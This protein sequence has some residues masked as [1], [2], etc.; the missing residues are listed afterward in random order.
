MKPKALLGLV[1]RLG[2]A[3]V[4]VW[5]LA[6]QLQ[7]DDSLV[8]VD[9]TELTGSVV[10][11]DG[12]AFE[13]KL[14]GEAPVV[15]VPADEVRERAAGVPDVTYGLRTL[16]ARL[17]ERP[18]AG[19][20]VLL[21]LGVVVVLTG[22]RW[23]RLLQAV[24]LPVGFVEAVR[25]TFVGGFFNLVVPGST[26]GDVVKAYYAA[27][28][29][30]RP[31]RAVLSVF[32]D[33]LIGVFT[34]VVVAAGALLFAGD[35]EGYRVARLTTFSLL[36]AGT[37]GM[38]LVFSTRVRRGLGVS[39]L[40]RKLPFQRVIDEMSAAVRLYRGRPR[41]LF[42]AFL[43]SV[44][45][46]LTIAGVVWWLAQALSIPGVGLGACFAFVPLINLLSAIPLVPGGWG[47]GELAF[48]YFFGQ[49]Q[50]PATEAIS[51]SVIFRLSFLLVNLPG[52]LLWILMRGQTPHDTMAA[53]VEAATQ[54]VGAVDPASVA[55]DPPP[56]SQ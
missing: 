16:G 49:V 4:V 48:A 3:A 39:K 22:W 5:V 36:G 20:W 25:L 8:R 17:L 51:L 31:T 45:N 27:K 1:V 34:L 50:V 30:G 6:S 47:V 7:I 35:G 44:V 32:V 15:V 14:G 23:Q 11:V 24:D 26:G 40:I 18:L 19:F 2:L 42:L 29:T 52:G 53:T 38:L 43:I 12:G 13:V 55:S 10:R 28:R 41:E 21:A 46:Q 56:E 9:E 33:R 37:L 54:R